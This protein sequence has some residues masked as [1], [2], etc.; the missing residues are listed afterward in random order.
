ML[1]FSL[2]KLQVYIEM[3]AVNNDISNILVHYVELN[4]IYTVPKLGVILFG[5]SC[6]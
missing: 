2:K 1:I 3:F 6:I 4:L 5:T